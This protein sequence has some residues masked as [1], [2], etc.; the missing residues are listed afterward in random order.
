MAI[1]YEPFTSISGQ[2]FILRKNE[3]GSYSYIPTDP[4]HSD[5]Q[6]YLKSL[7]A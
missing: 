4:A 7:E 2:D 6:E 5:Y 3:D 1:S